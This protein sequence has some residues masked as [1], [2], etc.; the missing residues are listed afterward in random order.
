MR[1]R[2]SEEILAILRKEVLSE[3]RGRAGLLNSILFSIVT[4]V[5][6]SLA[7]SGNSISPTFAAG[8]VWVAL[9][10]AGAVALPRSFT[11]EEEQQTGDLLRLMAR[12][13]A[14]F[15]GKA[16][17]NLGLMILV[18]LV[19]SGLFLVL[20]SVKADRPTEAWLFVLSLLGASAALSG[21]VTLCGALVAQAA[22]RATLAGTISLPLLLPVLFLGVTSTK[23]AL[24]D[25]TLEH[26]LVATA[27]LLSYGVASM[28]LGPYLFAAIWKS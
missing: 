20:V 2:W 7:T 11:L 21:A 4:V 22:N 27:G 1:S 23:A 6:V 28:A 5:A 13:H 9:L 16:L 25:G 24:G 3:V 19:L 18:A 15:W 12:P 8:L 14:V 10:F 17:Y 26:G